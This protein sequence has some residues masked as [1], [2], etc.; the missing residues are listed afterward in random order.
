MTINEEGFWGRLTGK[1]LVYATYDDDVYDE[2]T[3]E[4]LHQKGDWKTDEFGNYYAETA[5]G[6]ENIGKEFVNVSEVLT[7]DGS[8][9]NAIDIFDSDDITQ[10]IP[11]TVLKTAAIIGST[12]IPYFGIG[13]IIKYTTAAIEFAKV[14][15][16]MAKTI[17]GFFDSDGEYDS[18]NK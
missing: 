7:T 11:K 16:Q 12:F 10:N 4:L 14:L 3:G 18:L 13:N 9:W 2:E 8:A 15:P 5:E 17:N 6:K 1:S